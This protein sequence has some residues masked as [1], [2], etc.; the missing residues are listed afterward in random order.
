MLYIRF[1]YAIFTPVHLEFTYNYI[2][3]RL[4]QQD[5]FSIQNA[6]GYSPE[7]S[8]AREVVVYINTRV[9]VPTCGAK[10]G[11]LGG[12]TCEEAGRIDHH[13]VQPFKVVI[14]KEE[15]RSLGSPLQGGN[16][17]NTYTV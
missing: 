14:F 12:P 9:V 2:L 15:F 6:N 3:F 11:V 10:R 8:G 5:H 1:T 13:Q 4:Q 7:S 16:F 17:Q